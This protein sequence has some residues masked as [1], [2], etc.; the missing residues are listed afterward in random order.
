MAKKS[1]KEIEERRDSVK[2]LV[3]KGWKDKD[4]M[5]K[6]GISRDILDGDRESIQ[7]AYIHA[8]TDDANMFKRQAEHILKH[9]DQLDMVK[10]KLWELEGS[11]DSDKGRIEA[12]KTLLTEL[13][14]ESKILKLIDS[15]KT[16]VKN[17]IHVD[18]I[19]ILMTKLTEVIRE[20]VPEDKQQYAFQRIKDLGPALENDA[21][22][23]IDITTEKD[24]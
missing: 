7:E 15:S 1:V 3:L 9:L 21:S 23:V 14:H 4:I 8:I 5:D 20:F 17:Y 12:L 6:L 24:E 18:K 10:K 22:K 13:E 19:N 16:I 2:E 11:A